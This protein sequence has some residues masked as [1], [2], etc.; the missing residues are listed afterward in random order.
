[1][2]DEPANRRAR[3]R[4][5]GQRIAPLARCEVF[6]GLGDVAAHE[7]PVFSFREHF[8]APSDKCAV[9]VAVSLKLVHQPSRGI[10]EIAVDTVHTREGRDP[11]VALRV[12]PAIDR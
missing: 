5:A 12:L 1:M 2:S 8:T 4:G 7:L 11:V 6:T 3:C 9:R 10:A